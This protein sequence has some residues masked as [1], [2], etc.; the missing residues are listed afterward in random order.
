VD[1]VSL[2]IF[3]WDESLSDKKSPIQLEQISEVTYTEQAQVYP[4]LPSAPMLPPT[5]NYGS[6][7]EVIQ[8]QPSTNQNDIND[9]T[10]IITVNGCPICRIGVLED[11]YR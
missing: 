9:V 5:Q 3:F 6:I 8:S 11:D 7:A 10:T 4:V 1:R 2:N